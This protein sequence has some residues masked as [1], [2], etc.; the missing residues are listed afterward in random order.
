MQTREHDRP[1]TLRDVIATV[2]RMTRNERET[3]EVVNHMLRCE[4]I[5]FARR[6]SSAE[7]HRLLS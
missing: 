3:A 6:R 4:R 7:F 2:D 5:A 1:L